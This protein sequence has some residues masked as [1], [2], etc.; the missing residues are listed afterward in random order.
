MKRNLSYD[1]RQE[2][3]DRLV[4]ERILFFATQN[5]GKIDFVTRVLDREYGINVVHFP[6]DLSEIRAD[7]VEEVAKQKAINAYEDVGA[8]CITLDSGFFIDAVKGW[9]GTYVND[10][11]N[12]LG[13]EGILRLLDNDSRDCHIRPVLAYYDGFLSHPVYFSTKL[14][15]TLSQKPRGERKKYHWSDLCKIFIPEGFEKTE[16]EMT[17]ESYN[18]WR[19]KT[20]TTVIRFGE[21]FNALYGVSKK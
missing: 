4:H 17:E 7:T 9:P 19:K 21:W 6:I 1:R 13:I 15:G 10:A 2:S 11:L 20:D 12:K 14:K 8:P 3:L 5:V 16:A 18:K